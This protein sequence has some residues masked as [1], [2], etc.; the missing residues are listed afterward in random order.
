M[1]TMSVV[2]QTSRQLARPSRLAVAGILWLC[3]AGVLRAQSSQISFTGTDY[4]QNFDSLPRA[5][6]FVYNEQGPFDVPST[7]QSALAG[8]AFGRI[9][10]LSQDAAFMVGDGSSA[11]DGVYSF[12]TNGS[13][14]RA[15]GS[16]AGP[17][18]TSTF[19]AIFVN[20]TGST[21]NSVTI[22]FTGEQWRQA[23]NSNTLLFQYAVGAGSITNGA[24]TSFNALNFTAL[25]TGPV[26]ALNGNLAIN[27]RQISATITGLNWTAG[28]TLAIRWDD[29]NDIRP[30]PGM[31]VDN[32][33]L[34]IP[35]PATVAA[36]CAAVI[37]MVISLRNRRAKRCLQS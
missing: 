2:A 36:G 21:L 24:F 33:S 5:G 29:E 3:L 6:N 22:S 25:R 23:R 32:F 13:S 30:E 10:G 17:T 35:E 11:A 18:R 31:A 9:G 4:F 1:D 8:W 20:N 28:S 27:Q 26:G 34:T 19:G 12:G 37:L 15:L 14:E 16:L 7:P